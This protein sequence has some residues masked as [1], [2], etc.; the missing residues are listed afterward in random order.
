MYTK[1]LCG[2]MCLPGVH[3]L[4]NMCIHTKVMYTVFNARG[5]LQNTAPYMSHS[6]RTL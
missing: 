3:T 2:P 4:C 6:C 1:R 5:L